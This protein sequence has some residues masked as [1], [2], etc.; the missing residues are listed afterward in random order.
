LLLG[1]QERE[2]R[3]TGPPPL[4]MT[5]ASPVRARIAAGELGD[6]DEGGLVIS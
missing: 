5:A 3:P 6:G 1:E 2:N 4:M